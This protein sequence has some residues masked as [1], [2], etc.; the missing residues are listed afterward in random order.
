VVSERDTARDRPSQPVSILGF[1]QMNTHEHVLA[2]PS[3]TEFGCHQSASR[4]FAMAGLTPRDV[5]VAEIYDSFT[6][7]VLVEL[8]SIG[9]FGK[10][11]AGPAIVDGALELGGILPCNTHGGLLS[12]GHSG[13]AGGMFHIVEAVRQ[14]RGGAGERQVPG[15]EI[16]F[17]HGDGGVLS[18]HCSLILGSA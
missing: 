3:L 8:E 12:Y 10:G 5:D 11:E 16:A 1:G 9:F 17:V 13:A 7:T 6:I 18:S 14:L 4:A 15:A 2:M